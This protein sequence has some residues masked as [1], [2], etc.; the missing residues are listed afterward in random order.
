ETVELFIVH[1]SGIR[2]TWFVIGNKAVDFL[3]RVA[4]PIRGFL[5]VR[6]LHRNGRRLK[7][8]AGHIA[9]V[10]LT[11]GVE[12]TGALLGNHPTAVT[13]LETACRCH[14]RDHPGCVGRTLRVKLRL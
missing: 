10:A 4:F 6:V 1:V 13:L 14:L 9:L 8:L 2:V 3:T 7:N 5:L 12:Y 11:R